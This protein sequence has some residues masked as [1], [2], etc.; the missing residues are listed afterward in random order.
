MPVSGKV[1]DVAVDLRRHSPTLGQWQAVELSAENKRI[2]WIPPGFGHGFIV[3]SDSADFLYKASAYYNP[4]GER[5]ILWN[6]PT[7]GIPW[8]L[9]RP[10]ILSAKDAAGTPFKL[11]DVYETL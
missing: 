6:D 11:A 10:P 9:D 1:F 2:F 7:L 4:D 5:S 3:L 8:P